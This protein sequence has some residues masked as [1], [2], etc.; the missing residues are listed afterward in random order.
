MSHISPV[1]ARESITRST[2][3]DTNKIAMYELATCRA[4][5]YLLKQRM[6]DCENTIQSLKQVVASVA[7]KQLEIVSQMVELRKNFFVLPKVITMESSTSTSE[8]GV[9]EYMS[10]SESDDWN[11][12]SPATRVFSP[13][14]S[15][16]ASSESGSEIEVARPQEQEEEEDEE[17]GEGEGEQEYDLTSNSMS[18]WNIL[19]TIKEEIEPE[20]AQ[21]EV[22]TYQIELQEDFT[23]SLFQEDN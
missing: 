3:T 6:L 8:D 11:A 13:Y 16:L 4:E 1:Q 5:N 17:E 20:D 12:T 7:D 21:E 19:Y 22:I 9:L 2:E 23:Q 15:P 18:S 10:Y 14:I